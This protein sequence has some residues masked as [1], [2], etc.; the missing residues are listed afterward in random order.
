[1][2]KTML[3]LL[4][5][6]AF[7]AGCSTV[8]TVEPA[9]PQSVKKMV[10][11]KRIITDDALDGFAYVAGV[12]ESTVGGNLLK[13]QVQLINSTVALR[14][15][16]YKF[17]WLDESGMAIDSPNTPW[18]TV[19]LEGGESKYISSVAPSARAKDFNLKLMGNVR[20]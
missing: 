16:N 13:V 5:A 20:D 3:I 1:M 11:D 14:Q 17:E 12:N 18:L 9:K 7:V 19:S 10:D 4:G 2:K 8:N 6:C 15:V